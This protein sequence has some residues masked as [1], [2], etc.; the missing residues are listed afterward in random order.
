[1]EACGFEKGKHMGLQAH[2]NFVADPEILGYVVMSERITC[3]CKVVGSD[4]I[5]QLVNAIKIHVMIATIF[6]FT[7]ET[8]IERRF[9]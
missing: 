5:S 1:M 2:H 6:L 7:K 8:T 9:H 4:S 3:L